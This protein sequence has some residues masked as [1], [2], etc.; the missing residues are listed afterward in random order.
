ME[1][2]NGIA[3]VPVY[4]ICV[5]RIREDNISGRLY[6][7]K[8]PQGADFSGLGEVMLTIDGIMDE[9][10]FPQSTVDKRSFGEKEE[11]DQM[12]SPVASKEAQLAMRKFNTKTQQG[13]LAT[14]VMQVQFR[15]NASWQGTMEWVENNETFPFN[16]ELELIRMIDKICSKQNPDR[17]EERTSM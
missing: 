2:Q 16:S 14:F 3:L 1:N 8:I 7:G 17:S 4:Q 11:S 6:C 15:Q 5:D 12:I 9:I 10:D 13:K